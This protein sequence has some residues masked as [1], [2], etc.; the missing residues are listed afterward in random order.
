[1]IIRI[2]SI[3]LLTASLL[4]LL[5]RNGD[6]VLSEFFVQ[7]LAQ[8]LKNYLAYKS[9]MDAQFQQWLELGQD[10]SSLTRKAMTGVT[11]FPSWMEF[12]PGKGSKADPDEGAGG[13]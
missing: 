6:S 9:A 4:S 3:L 7:Y 13:L 2:A 1:M 10:L 11:P 8:P 5:I 12:F